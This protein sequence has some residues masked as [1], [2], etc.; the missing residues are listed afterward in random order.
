MFLFLLSLE[1]NS[2][3]QYWTRFIDKEPD[4]YI[5]DQAINKYTVK[6]SEN[7]YTCYILNSSTT[8]DQFMSLD[9]VVDQL[10]KVLKNYESTYK[11]GEKYY[12]NLKH[13]SSVNIDTKNTKKNNND[14]LWSTIKYNH[15]YLYET[16]NSLS[17]ELENEKTIVRIHYKCDITQTPYGGIYGVTRNVTSVYDSENLLKPIDVYDIIYNTNI[18]CSY[19]HFLPPK[20]CIIPC[21]IKPSY[22]KYR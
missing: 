15:E 22:S 9:S 1:I 14:I 10:M 21:F 3:K 17:L 6:G 8:E 18:L 2:G 20:V 5:I 11:I 16:D 7:E 19:E 12:I 4:R 13:F